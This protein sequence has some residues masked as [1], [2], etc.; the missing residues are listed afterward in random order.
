MLDIIRIKSAS[1]KGNKGNCNFLQIPTEW[2]KEYGILTAT[3]MHMHI[4]IMYVSTWLGLQTLCSV[5]VHG[6]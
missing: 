4:L 5:R 3:Y 6:L 1:V 2:S